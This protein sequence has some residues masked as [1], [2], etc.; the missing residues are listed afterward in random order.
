[1]IFGAIETFC[2]GMDMKLEE[3]EIRRRIETI[4]TTALL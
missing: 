2:K 3:L 4:P 1:M